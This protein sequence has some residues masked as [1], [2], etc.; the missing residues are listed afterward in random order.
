MTEFEDRNAVVT[1]AGRGIG[2]ATAQ[3]FAAR[4]ASVVACSRTQHELD[5]LVRTI[6]EGGGRAVGVVADLATVDGCADLAMRATNELGRIDML[7]NNVGGS[8][9]GRIR[10]LENDDWQAALELNFL[11]AVRVTSALLPS[12]VPGP[13]SIVNISSTSGREPARLFGPYAAAK[14]QPQR[15]YRNS[16]RRGKGRAITGI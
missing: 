15:P 2:Q 4:G 12:M 1:G 16:M 5:E 6:Q 7:V 3:L 13:A 14:R 8:R 9:P 10:E 11:S